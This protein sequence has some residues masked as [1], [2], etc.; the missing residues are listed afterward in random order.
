M[1]IV[2]SMG[3]HQSHEQKRRVCGDDCYEKEGADGIRERGLIG[4]LAEQPIAKAI[5]GSLRRSPDL[6]GSPTRRRNTEADT[7]TF[8]ASRFTEI[9]ELRPK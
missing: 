3:M 8:N 7:R 4:W 1:Q 5:T 2:L 6:P 9:L